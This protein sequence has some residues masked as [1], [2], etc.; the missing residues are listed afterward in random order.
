MFAPALGLVSLLIAWGLASYLL[1][2]D[3][4]PGPLQVLDAGRRLLMDG[5]LGDN[6]LVSLRRVLIGFFVGVVAGVALGLL[7][8]LS[9][10]ASRTV[11]VLV[12]LLRPVPGIAWLPLAVLWFGLGEASKIFLISLGVFF[13][14]FVGAVRGIR[15]TDPLHVRSAQALG[16]SR[17]QVIRDVHLPSALPE[18][19][20]GQRVGI[21]LG[22]I[23]MVAAE[24][25]SGRSGLGY[26]IAYARIA[27]QPDQIYV[28]ILVIGAL[29]L[30]LGAAQK[31]MEQYM[32]RWHAGLERARAA[33]PRPTPMKRSLRSALTERG[34]GP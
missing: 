27:G 19:L 26:M 11:Y 5:T 3:V 9:W 31:G 7:A 17:W 18:I 2:S 22:F 34:N 33:P 21:S 20:T 28:G 16:A 1:R 30:A 12:E 6:T 14:V 29:S 23:Y 25:I 4:L 24:L 32:L 10:F 13:P 8:G 15:Q